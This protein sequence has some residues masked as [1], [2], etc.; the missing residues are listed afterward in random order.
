MPHNLIIIAGKP[1]NNVQIMAPAHF[2]LGR[3]RK[4]N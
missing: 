1:I 3:K 2:G 4:I